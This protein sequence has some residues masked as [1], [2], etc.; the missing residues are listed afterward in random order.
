MIFLE[1]CNLYRIVNVSFVQQILKTTFSVICFFKINQ[2]LEQV[3]HLKGSLRGTASMVFASESV[4]ILVPC[5][6]FGDV[7][8][9][10]SAHNTCADLCFVYF[11]G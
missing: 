8:Q 4:L 5:Q 11:V 7:L 9:F 1:N 6:I 3:V 10:L 2:A